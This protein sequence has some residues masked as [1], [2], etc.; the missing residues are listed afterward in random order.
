MKDNVDL[1]IEHSELKSEK[2]NLVSKL[3]NFHRENNK[4]TGLIN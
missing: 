4:M 3:A 2:L 1:Q